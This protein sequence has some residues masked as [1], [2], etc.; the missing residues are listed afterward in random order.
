MASEDEDDAIADIFQ[1]PDGY[2]QP[3]EPPHFVEHTL[4]SGQ[5]LRLRLVGS[6]PL[7]VVEPTTIHE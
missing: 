3:K 4:L 1:E 2:F 5:T 6:N 7:W